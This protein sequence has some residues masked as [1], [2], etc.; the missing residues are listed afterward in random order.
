MKLNIFRRF[1]HKVEDELVEEQHRHSVIAMIT[2]EAKP[3]TA[4]WSLLLLSAL[5]AT[6]GL[7]GDNGAVIIGAMIIAP[8]IWP[9]LA[10]SMSVVKGEAKHFGK[11]L[12]LNILNIFVA[13]AVSVVITLPFFG[14]EY[15]HEILIRTSPNVIDLFIAIFSGVVAALSVAWPKISSSIAG[16]A[17][18]ASLMP[19]LAV[20]GI[21]I[22]NLD[23]R[24]AYG[25]L[26][27]FLTN[28]VAIFM[29]SIIVFF[30]LGFRPHIF[31]KKE[32]LVRMRERV[33]G[34]VIIFILFLIPF[35]YF[36]GQVYYEN[37]LETRSRALLRS[38]LVEHDPLAHIRTFQGAYTGTT[39]QLSAEILVPFDKPL[40]LADHDGFRDR[41]SEK[42]EVPVELQL[43]SI[44]IIGSPETLLSP[45]ESGIKEIIK[46]FQTD[47]DINSNV[48]R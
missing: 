27:L 13:I 15:S 4:Y 20:V 26:L 35:S 29:V 10:L 41:L 46:S 37:N 14:Q 47:T 38:Y 12:V 34:A 1:F 31:L 25:A 24:L 16:V 21:G 45:F 43:L 33:V 42:L 6:L 22:A 32:A 8:L 23:F 17:V 5:I 7:H 39:L 11:V 36:T 48:S 18:A 40:S 9:I 30:A 3:D 44:P 28:V 2:E 19:P